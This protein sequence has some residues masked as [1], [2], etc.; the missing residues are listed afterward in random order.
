MLIQINTGK[1]SLIEILSIEGYR[2]KKVRE[3]AEDKGQF[4]STSFNGQTRSRDARGEGTTT[5]KG[6]KW[7]ALAAECSSS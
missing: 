3:Y 7:A 2:R 6:S 5:N 1:D 4:L